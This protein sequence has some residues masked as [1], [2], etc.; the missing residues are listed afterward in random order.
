MKQ[1]ILGLLAILFFTSCSSSDDDDDNIVITGI[2]YK[3]TVTGNWTGA[4]HPTDYP[5]NS[6]FSPV[7]GMTHKQG[8]KIF[9][10]NK[11]ASDG[12]EIMAETGG[13]DKLLSEI[14]ELIIQSKANQSIRASGLSSGSATFNFTTTVNSNFP[15]ITLV[16]MIAP[17]PDWFV[18]VEEVNLMENG[19]FVNSKIVN[20]TVYDAGTDNGSTFTSDNADTN[21]AQNITLITGSP[22]GNGSGVTPYMMQIKFE[23]IQE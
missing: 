7:T 18:A 9:E 5:S 11:L 14:N 8:V 1:L 22:L 20:T 3:V 23:K 4:N 13:T 17:S 16:S 15:Y 6:H 21:P 10:I 2:K 19:S 12:I